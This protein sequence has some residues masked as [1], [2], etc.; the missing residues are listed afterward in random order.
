M[1]F[2][3]YQ[4]DFVKSNWPNAI[5]TWKKYK[6]H[7][8]ASLSHSAKE[9]GWGRSPLAVGSNNYFGMMS[10]GSTN[11]Y[12]DGSFTPGSEGR[13]WKKYKSPIQSFLDYGL[14]I[15]TSKKYQDAYKVA[16]KPDQYA[17]AISKSPYMTNADGRQK[18]LQDF[19]SINQSVGTIVSDLKLETV[20]NNGV[21]FISAIVAGFIVKR[22]FF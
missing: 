19:V 11:T 6:I 5:A 18:Y 4:I 12:W 17:E 16:S 1:A 8:I 2:A 15:S 14:L 20:S 7:P 10:A 13:K 22:L 9:T 21:F 3:Q